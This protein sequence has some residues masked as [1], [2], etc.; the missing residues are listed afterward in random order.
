MGVGAVILHGDSVLL[1]KR[2]HEPM[3]GGWSLPGGTV[4]LGETLEDA[5][6]REIREETCL[7]VEVGPMVDVVDRIQ[8]D[9]DG[10]VKYHHVLVDFVCRPRGGELRCASDA[11]DAAWAPLTDLAPYA[12][13]E[14]TVSVISKAVERNV[15]A[16]TPREVHWQSE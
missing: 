12:V 13:A 15:S 10:R 16:W 14:A 2:A 9:P 1:V 11:E 6:R 7:E 3:K 5:I 8:Y 4:E